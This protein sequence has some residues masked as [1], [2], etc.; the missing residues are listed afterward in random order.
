VKKKLNCIWGLFA[1]E[2]FSKRDLLHRVR[3]FKYR[4]QRPFVFKHPPSVFFGQS[5]RPDYF[6]DKGLK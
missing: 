6:E 2:D 5:V 3:K 1:A 4:A